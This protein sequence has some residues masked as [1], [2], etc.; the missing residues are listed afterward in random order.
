M[1]DHYF[2]AAPRV[3]APAGPVPDPP[4][5]LNWEGLMD[6]ALTQARMAATEGEVPVG[7]VLAGPD[8][9]ILAQ[10]RNAPVALCDP[11]AH[12]EILA[13]RAAG[14]A[15]GNY[16]LNGCVLVVTLEPCAMCAAALVHARLAGVVYGAADARAGAVSSCLDGLAYGLEGPAP[17]HYGGVEAGPCAAVLRAFFAARR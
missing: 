12:A 7:A 15:L 1:Q 8:G 6:L 9:R 11:T 14:A 2:V 16:R 5:G 10:C 17:W 4:P 3:F 13:L